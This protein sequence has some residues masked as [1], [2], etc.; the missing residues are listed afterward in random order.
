MAAVPQV[1]L[2]VAHQRSGLPTP[3]SLV[4]LAAT[5][6]RWGGGVLHGDNCVA[7]SGVAAAICCG[8]RA[9]DSL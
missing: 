5:G 2:A 1:S 6:N 9:G 3:H 7:E 8:P 4:L